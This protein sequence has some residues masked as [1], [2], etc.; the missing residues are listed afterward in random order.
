VF[1]LLPQPEHREVITAF[2]LRPGKDEVV[3]AS[4]NQLLR[5]WVLE[6]GECKRAWKAHKTPVLSMD[7]DPTGTLVATGSSD[8]AVMVRDRR[9]VVCCGAWS[10]MSV[11][12]VVCL[13][14]VVGVW[15]VWDVDKGYCTHSFRQHSGIVTT[16]KFHFAPRKLLLVSLCSGN[17]VRVWDLVHKDHSKHLK[18]HMGAVTGASFAPDGVTLVTGARDKVLSFWDLESGRLLLTLPVYEELETVEH[19]PAE[20][21]QK[22]LA[23][24]TSRHKLAGVTFPELRR[25]IAANARYGHRVRRMLP[26]Q[27]PHSVL[28][29]NAVAAQFPG[30]RRQPWDSPDVGMVAVGCHSC[31]LCLCCHSR[32]DWCGTHG[33]DWY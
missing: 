28:H 31:L 6:S 17:E 14:V 5:H 20:L 7:F 25:E 4:Q 33:C 2:A 10:L 19:L 15:Q 26:C 13:R 12:C 22:F 18:N 3:T 29:C 32:C 1:N 11:T 24:R 8:R 9:S 30:D 23:Y 16:V 21:C 27:F